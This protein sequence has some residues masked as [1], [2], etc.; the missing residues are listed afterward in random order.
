V[1]SITFFTALNPMMSGDETYTISSTSTIPTSSSLEL[2]E[3]LSITFC[4]GSDAIAMYEQYFLCSRFRCCERGEEGRRLV[5]LLGKGPH[6]AGKTSRTFE[7]LLYRHHHQNH[8]IDSHWCSYHRTVYRLTFV[9]Y[10]NI[11]SILKD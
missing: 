2:D 6:L 3:R 1:V 11:V 9:C 10:L 7:D 4:S 5:R 8:L